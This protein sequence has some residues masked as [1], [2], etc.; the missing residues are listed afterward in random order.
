MESHVIKHHTSKEDAQKLKTYDCDKCQK[1][2]MGKQLFTEHLYSGEKC[3]KWVKTK[4]SLDEHIAKYHEHT[5]QLLDCPYQGCD[6][7]CGN[8]QALKKHIDWHK[9]IE[10]KEKER[11]KFLREQKRHKQQLER[12]AKKRQI[13]KTTKS[14]PAKVIPGSM[15]TPDFPP[16][17]DRKT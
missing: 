11:A 1:K 16:Y 17:N 3:N 10:R 13:K 7:K 9:D 6:Q 5:S 2:F 8:K 15:Q 12:A 14:S 4:E